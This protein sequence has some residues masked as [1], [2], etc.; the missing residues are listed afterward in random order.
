ML[1]QDIAQKLDMPPDLLEKVSLRAYLETRRREV[2]AQLFLLAKKH[3]VATVQ[4]FDLAVQAGRIREAEGFEDFFV[5]DRLVSEL[6]K[7][8]QAIQTLP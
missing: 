6:D 7:I 8:L 5:F 4:E 3:G 1:T 2:E